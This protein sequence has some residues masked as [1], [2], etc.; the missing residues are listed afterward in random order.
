LAI[1]GGVEGDAGLIKHWTSREIDIADTGTVEP[2]Y[3]ICPVV[4]VKKGML[5]K[6]RG[7]AQPVPTL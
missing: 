4:D 7:F 6:I 5:G 2:P 3:P 1:D